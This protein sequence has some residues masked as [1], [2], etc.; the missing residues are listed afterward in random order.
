LKAPSSNHAFSKYFLAILPSAV[1]SS[2]SL[3][4]L[5]SKTSSIFSANFLRYASFSL[6][7]RG[8]IFS[9]FLLLLLFHTVLVYP[10]KKSVDDACL[11][12]ES[13]FIFKAV[14]LAVS[15]D[16]KPSVATFDKIFP[17]ADHLSISIVFILFH[18]AASSKAL[19]FAFQ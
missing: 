11:Q 7:F 18:I 4:C 16:A 1:S 3:I 9:I 10:L 8:F 13:S 6:L 19:S 2:P 15:I 17:Q 14:T 12:A 5:S